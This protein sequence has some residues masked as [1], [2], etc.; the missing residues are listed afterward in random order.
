MIDLHIHSTCSDGSDEPSSLVEE[1]KK[2]GLAGMA[3]TDHDTM[4]GVG[5]FLDACRQEGMTGIAGIEFSVDT[6]E[7]GGSLHMLG[8]GLDPEYPGVVEALE[9]VQEG[10]MW[11][12][13]QILAKLNE[14]GMEL[15]WAE[16]EDCAGE[17]VIGR[18]HFAQAMINRNYVSSVPEAFEKYLAKGAPA[19]VDRYRL[20]PEECIP[21]IRAA[22]GV[23]VLAHPFTW[24][25]DP[26]EL[27]AE[28]VRLKE[29]GLYGI[30]A[31]HAEHTME[32]VMDLMRLAKRFDLQVTGGSDYHG[33]VKPDVAL[34]TGYGKL[35]VP[36]SCL[37]ALL[38]AI[39]AP[40][41]PRVVL[42]GRA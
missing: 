14:L 20:F 24:L 15:E 37:T 26:E 40:N 11:R 27:A 7:T 18:P 23:A 35:Q 34:G 21:L 13:E 32:Q 41:N 25:E 30:E 33:A 4:D 31:L 28:L 42:G 22:G 12:N 3:L 2:I 29:L 16:V 9:K 8:Y 5:E 17:D 36:D 6:E 19:Y 38:A 10:R 39:D 1:G